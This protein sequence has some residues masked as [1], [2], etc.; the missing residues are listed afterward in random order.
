MSRYDAKLHNSRAYQFTPKVLFWNRFLIFFYDQI[1]LTDESFS[2]PH[3]YQ[4]RNSEGVA[5]WI[6]FLCPYLHLIT[7][8]NLENFSDDEDSKVSKTPESSE[9]IRHFHRSRQANDSRRKLFRD[10]KRLRYVQNLRRE[11]EPIPVNIIENP[12]HE[13]TFI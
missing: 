3:L 12:L 11:R 7:V 8:E 1:H 6:L 10:S 5:N 2:F 4:T 9:S 13:S